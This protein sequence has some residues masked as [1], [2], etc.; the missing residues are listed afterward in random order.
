MNVE[1]FL[2]WMETEP[3]SY[4]LVHGQPVRMADENQGG[5]RMGNLIRAA[6]LSLGHPRDLDW[7]HTPNSAMEGQE[8]ALYVCESW[9]HLTAALQLL[10]DPENGHKLMGEQF[11]DIVARAER[12]A[13]IER[14]RARAAP[15]I[16]PCG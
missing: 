8:P 11:R 14:D 1:E 10:R 3:D 2:A 4:E 12:L 13:A 15:G 5:R 9:S 6:E 7:W 16:Q